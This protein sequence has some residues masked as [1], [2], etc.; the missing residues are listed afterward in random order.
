MSP[1]YKVIH[2]LPNVMLFHNIK[3]LNSFGKFNDI[4]KLIVVRFIVFPVRSDFFLISNSV[5][6]TELNKEITSC[7]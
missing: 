7:S 5:S 6:K 4:K 2:F 3:I 1:S